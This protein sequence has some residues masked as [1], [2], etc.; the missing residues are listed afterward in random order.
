VDR[1]IRL[2]DKV[3]LC[4]SEESLSSWWVDAEIAKAFD[5]EQRLMKER[6]GR[7]TLALIPLNLDGH[8]FSRKWESGLATQITRRFAPDFT[9]WESDNAKFEAQVENVIRVCGRMMAGG[10]LRQCRCSREKSKRGH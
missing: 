10:K 3:L 6:D 7:K 9:G 2:W 1:G 4:C 5:K 8:L